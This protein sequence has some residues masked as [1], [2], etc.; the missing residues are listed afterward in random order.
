MIFLLLCLYTSDLSWKSHVLTIVSKANK[1][2]GLLKRTCPLITDTRIRRTLYLSLVKSQLCYATEVWSPASIK[3][4]T[5]IERVQRRATRWILRTKI[6]EKTY[7]ERL[8]GL[9]LLPLTYDRELRDLVFFLKCYH[10]NTNLNINNF[11]SFVK[12]GRSRSM[13]PSLVL[14]P[15]LCKTTTFQS[16]FFNRIVKPW[17]LICRFADP[18][19]F[20]SLPCFKR[21]LKA[22][23]FSEL[24]TTYDIDFP[25]TWSLS[26]NCSCHRSYS[27]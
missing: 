9:N 23:F 4:K 17:N 21:F 25:C 7:K 24:S 19:I 12:H 27:I 20:S 15:A 6:G 18:V 2:L 8:T 22:A 3:L 11:V 13:N 5:I 16:S 26:R 1:M 14:K 10:G